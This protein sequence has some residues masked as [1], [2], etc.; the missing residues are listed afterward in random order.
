MDDTKEP[1]V[2]IRQKGMDNKIERRT[3]I[4]ITPRGSPQD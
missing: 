2:T 3:K 4:N 1:V